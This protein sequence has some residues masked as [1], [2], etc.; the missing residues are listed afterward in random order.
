MPISMSRLILYVRD[1]ELL[2]SFY[3]THFAFPVI[4]EIESEWAVL[5]A[6]EVEIA[7][8][9]VGVAYRDRPTSGETSNAKLV[10]SVRSGLEDLRET[11]LNA[12]VRM[13]EMKRYEGFPQSMCDG[14]DPEGNV[15]QLSQRD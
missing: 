9:R 13:R 14:E 3:R 10:F 2:K 1:V 11:L 8:H 15:F 7:L 6:G 5:K 12:G 4:E